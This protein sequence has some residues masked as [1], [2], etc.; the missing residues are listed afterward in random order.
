M[1][2]RVPDEGVLLTNIMALF[3]QQCSFLTTFL[4][5]VALQQSNTPFSYVFWQTTG[6]NFK[7]QGT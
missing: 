6:I 4:F 7:A 5:T 3:I 2:N 1:A